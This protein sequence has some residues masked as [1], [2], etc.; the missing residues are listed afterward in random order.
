MKR[1]LILPTEVKVCA[2]CSYWDGERKIDGEYGLVV[3]A[4]SCEGE[5][6]VQ[7]R[8]F[9]GLDGVHRLSEECSW[10]H[11]EPDAEGAASET[12]E[13]TEPAETTVSSLDAAAQPSIESGEEPGKMSGG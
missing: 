9:H 7:E 6:L 3:V 10:E 4:E 13:T 8:S 5:C 1:K 12:T 2:T 11:L